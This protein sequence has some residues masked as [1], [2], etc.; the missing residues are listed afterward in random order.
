MLG[1]SLL[2]QRLATAG[3]NIL[4]PQPTQ[5]SLGE[6][7]VPKKKEQHGRLDKFR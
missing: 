5:F 6:F 2:S 4:G 1:L 3:L 7:L